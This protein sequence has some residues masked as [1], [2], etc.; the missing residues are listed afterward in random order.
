ML[1]G[2]SE[3]PYGSDN[4]QRPSLSLTHTHTHAPHS[5]RYCLN[6]GTGAAVITA[7]VNY[8]ME[9]WGEEENRQR[10]HKQTQARRVCG[11]LY[12]WGTLT[13]EHVP[14][15]HRDLALR[16]QQALSLSDPLRRDGSDRAGWVTSFPGL[17]GIT[18]TACCTTGV[19]EEQNKFHDKYNPA[20]LVCHITV[21][22]TFSLQQVDILSG[23]R[24][25]K[26][27]L[28]RHRDWNAGSIAWMPTCRFV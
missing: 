8:R 26:T 6:R 21:T 9:P 15:V 2:F 10:V 22:E 16:V 14:R 24:A 27:F 12:T 11:E 20:G 28:L 19:K 1:I 5:G 7:G 17:C 23:C 25:C 13:C 18:V 4:P 3:A